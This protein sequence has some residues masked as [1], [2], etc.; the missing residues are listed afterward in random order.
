LKAVVPALHEWLASLRLM[1]HRDRIHVAPSLAGRTFVGFRITPGRRRI[2]NTNV[3]SFLRR[4]CWMRRGFRKRRL[5]R[6]DVQR[7]LMGWLGHAY[8][9]DSGPLIARLAKGW[10]VQRGRFKAFR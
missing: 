4:L 9:A 1:L 5:T 7:R 3:R 8:Q 10:V 6:D 2:R